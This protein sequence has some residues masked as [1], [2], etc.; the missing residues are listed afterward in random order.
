M[1]FNMRMAARLR[2]V[3]LV[4]QNREAVLAAARR[5]F[6]DKG[7][8]GATLEAIAEEAGFSKGVMYSQFESKADLF[9]TLLERRIDERSEQ[10]E[11]IVA[12][13]AGRDGLRMLFKVGAED[14]VREAAWARL[15]IEFRALAS[16]DPVVNARYAAAHARTVER[17]ASALER[18]WATATLESRFPPRVMAEFI[19]ALATGATLESAANPAALPFETLSLMVERGLGWIEPDGAA[20]EGHSRDAL[21]DGTTGQKERPR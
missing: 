21:R 15:L 1:V 18:L 20:F 3:E 16:R 9:L 7:Y 6:I 4:E 2:R 10:D 14:A 5:V 19:L 17:L 8:A 13:R 12:E 11:R